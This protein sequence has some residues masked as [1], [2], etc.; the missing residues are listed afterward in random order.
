MKKNTRRFSKFFH[1]VSLTKQ[2]FREESDINRIVGRY[3]PTLF[4]RARFS[5]AGVD[6]SDVGVVDNTQ[7]ADFH[8]LQNRLVALSASFGTL[9]VR[10]RERFS[11]DP[12][13]LL[14]FVSDERNFDEGVALGLFAQPKTKIPNPESGSGGADKDAKKASGS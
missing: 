8:D 2:S 11:N 12:R 10:I 1:D 9:P 14:M 7:F 4:A 13:R 6:T 5:C 3:S